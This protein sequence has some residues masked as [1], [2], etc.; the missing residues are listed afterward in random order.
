MCNA[1]PHAR[2]VISTDWRTTLV[3]LNIHLSKVSMC[4]QKLEFLLCLIFGYSEGSLVPL[5]LSAYSLLQQVEVVAAGWTGCTDYPCHTTHSGHQH[6]QNCFQG[7][8][9]SRLS[10]AEYLMSSAA[11]WLDSRLWNWSQTKGVSLQRTVA[12]FWMVCFL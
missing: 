3:M 6:E 4:P 11:F 7:L 2:S 12:L 1:V 10:A 8:A 5:P 9:S